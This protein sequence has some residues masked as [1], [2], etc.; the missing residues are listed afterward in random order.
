MGI[1]FFGKIKLKSI[2]K[3]IRYERLKNNL[4]GF[5]NLEG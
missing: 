3:I 1:H 4:Q 2:E 5:K